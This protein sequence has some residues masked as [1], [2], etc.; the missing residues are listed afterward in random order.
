MNPKLDIDFLRAR[1][2]VSTFSVLLLL[3]GLVAT[4]VTLS[5]Y[6]DARDAYDRAEL[7]QS[8]E[9]RLAQRDSVIPRR[10]GATAAQ[11]EEP[12]VQAVVTRLRLPWDGMLAELE[13]HADASVAL[14]NIESQGLGNGLRLTGEARSMDAVVA[15]VGRLAAAPQVRAATLS[16]HEERLSGTVRVVR[17]SLDLTWGRGS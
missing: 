9:Q 8:R 16:G 2:R 4:V 3:V 6:V 12:A 13:R 17:F 14:L 1:R 7:R 5:E 15:Y 11:T 10:T